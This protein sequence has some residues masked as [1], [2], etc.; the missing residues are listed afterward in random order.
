MASKYDIQRRLRRY[1]R[2]PGNPRLKGLMLASLDHTDA[3]AREV[4]EAWLTD[5][6]ERQRLME[7]SGAHRALQAPVSQTYAPGAHDDLPSRPEAGVARTLARDEFGSDDD[8][9]R[10]MAGETGMDKDT[11]IKRAL[12]NDSPTE[13]DVLF[14]EELETSMI[15]GAQP[16]KIF[17]DAANV[18]NVSK[19]KG[20]LPRESD[21]GYAAILGHS[22][23]IPTGEEGQDTVAYETVK[24]GQGFEISDAL[25]AEAEPD[26]VE[27]LARR[28]GAAV[29]NSVNR[30]CLVELID[31]AGNTFDADVGGTVDASAVQA[32]NGAIT[33]VQD[34]DFPTPDQAVV[35]AEFEQAIFDDTNVVYANRSGETQP[36]QQRQMGSIMGLD[37]WMASDSAYNNATNA[38]N[39]SSV[40]HTFGYAADGEIGGVVFAG[41]LFNLVIW[42]EFDMDTKDYEDPIRD[43]SGQNVRTW[44]DAKYGQASAA[45][46]IQY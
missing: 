40:D 32:L 29:E 11:Y 17:R 41:D 46:E 18:V 5:P 37:R 31:S 10:F 34:A 9:K 45:A 26:I 3:R 4:G 27:S 36:L 33:K 20:D 12:L 42:Q 21:E 30:L 28:T 22:D 19:R 15:M 24:I 13:L 23:E 39:I 2:E 7:H 35:H 43:L 44:A 8:V 6:N 1:W 14:R 25:A 38:K 16:R